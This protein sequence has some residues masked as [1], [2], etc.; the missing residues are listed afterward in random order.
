MKVFFTKIN[1]YRK[2]FS[3][4]ALLL[5]SLGLGQVDSHAQCFDFTNGEGITLQ[6]ET[7]LSALSYKAAF[8]EA[9]PDGMTIGECS[10]QFSSSE[11][12]SLHFT[13][14]SPSCESSATAGDFILGPSEPEDAF[15][16]T[17]NILVDDL[18]QLDEEEV[19]LNATCSSGSPVWF[20]T[21]EPSEENIL[22]IGT[23]FNPIANDPR[24]EEGAGTYT[25]YVRCACEG[26]NVAYSNEFEAASFTLTTSPTA[27]AGSDKEIC[28]GA[29]TTLGGLI[30]IPKVNELSENDISYSWSPTTGL[31]SST[32]A[33]PEASPEET[34]TYTLTVTDNNGTETEADDC[35]NTDEVKVTVLPNC[36]PDLTNAPP[37]VQITNS[38]C[39]EVGGS[40]SE[41]SI[42]APVILEAFEEGGVCPTGSTLMY[43]TDGTNFSTTL[44]TYNQTTEMTISTRCDCDMETGGETLN[45]EGVTSPVSTITTVPGVCPEAISYGSGNELTFGDPCKCDDPRNCKDGG[46]LYFH[47]TL[48]V[49]STGTVAS[50]LDIRINSATDFLIAVPCFGGAL[51]TPTLGAAGTRILETAVGSGVYKIEFWRPSGVQPTLTVIESGTV[52][53]APAATFQPICT[54][55]ACTPTAPIPTMSEWG[56]MIF[57]LLIL[58]LSVFFVQRTEIA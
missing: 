46:V 14:S 13:G 8:E 53:P 36:C 38:T 29:S 30:L 56:L 6:F 58:N 2:A 15:L 48:T 10:Y 7:F 32:S 25:Y 40:P 20:T 26:D 17:N 19:A 45:L 42:A 54:E 22:G 52:T 39:S 23:S 18:T 44:P 16:C 24:F 31:S 34:T 11:I 1:F 57:G 28:P 9:F 43:S 47:D 3:K 5:F 37:A 21:Q 33:R 4:M 51:T 50:G 49:P 12:S 41:G 35:T 55:E 27:S